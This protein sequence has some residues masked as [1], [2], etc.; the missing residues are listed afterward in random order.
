MYYLFLINIHYGAK[1]KMQVLTIDCCN[2][3]TTKPKVHFALY[4]SS[5]IHSYPVSKITNQ[6][7]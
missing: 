4:N 3:K 7:T 6:I 5:I 1:L 2:L